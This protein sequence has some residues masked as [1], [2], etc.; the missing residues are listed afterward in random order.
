MIPL[1]RSRVVVALAAVCLAP[2]AAGALQSET[3]TSPHYLT[4]ET[5]H[6]EGTEPDGHTSLVQ[7]AVARDTL[8]RQERVRFAHTLG[9]APRGDVSTDGS[10]TYVVVKRDDAR[11]TSDLLA[12]HDSK[13]D[14]WSTEAYPGSRP[15]R[16]PEGAKHGVYVAMG[17]PEGAGD[18][19]HIAHFD[20][21]G[22]DHSVFAS[23]ALTLH[24]IAVRARDIL[25]YR[26][27]EERAS[28]LSIAR[29]NGS[30]L[31]ETPILGY[32][33]DFSSDGQ[34]V[35][36]SNRAPGDE[37]LWLA[38]SWNPSS[39]AVTTLFASSQQ[40]PLVFAGVPITHSSQ[41]SEDPLN[42]LTDRDRAHQWQ[43]E[44]QTSQEGRLLLRSTGG[45]RTWRL[46][47]DHVELE[48]VGFASGETLR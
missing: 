4:L 23:H 47:S 30:V 46:G 33:R 3:A 48:G 37:L 35:V 25:L 11:A 12:I 13:V 29:D 20:A 6:A 26:L 8:T 40:S 43:A 41:G 17:T 39:G 28:L 10:H 42:Y 32:A 31:L 38:Q 45:S 19:V 5:E 2:A 24:L 18:N 36:Y 14:V 15:C 44:R 21:S 9:E 16:A 27:D 22:A 7:Y 1:T 34:S